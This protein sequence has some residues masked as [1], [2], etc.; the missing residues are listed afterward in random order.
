MQSVKTFLATLSILLLLVPGAVPISGLGFTPAAMAQ[1]APLADEDA[2]AKASASLDTQ[3]KQ[4]DSVSAYLGASDIN[5]RDILT[6][7]SKVDDVL[8]ALVVMKAQLNPRLDAM[9]ARLADLGAAP[10]DDQ[11][12]EALEVT[13]QRSK[14]SA[15][16]TRTV[17]VLARI[18]DMTKVA[19]DLSAKISTIR[20]E[21]FTRELLAHADVSIDSMTYAVSTV[22]PEVSRFADTMGNWLGFV[23]RLKAMSLASA[24]VLS[25][26]MMLGLRVVLHRIFGPIVARGRE[27]QDPSYMSRFSLAFWVTIIPSLGF[28]FFLGTSFLF[29]DMFNVLRPDI[30]QIIGSLFVFVGFLFFAIR[31]SLVVFNPA[32][33]KWRLLHVSDRGSRQLMAA[34]VTM[35][36][37]NGFDYVLSTISEVEG[38]PV[39]ITVLKGLL[40][41]IIVGLVLLWVSFIKPLL[42]TDELSLETGRPWPPLTVGLLRLLSAVIIFSALLGYVGFARFIVTQIVLTGGVVCTMYIGIRSGKAVSERDRFADTVVGRFFE[43]RFA[44]GPVALDQMGIAA[45][46]LIYIVAVL[47]GVPLIMM[48]WGFQPPDIRLWLFDLFTEIKIGSIS[49]SVVGII[50]GG[51]LFVVGMLLTRWF[52]KWLD[53]NVMARS[54]MD[55]GVRNSVKT[56]VGYFGAIVAAVMGL[57]AAGIN[58]SSLALVAG[59]LSVGIGFGLQNIISNFVSGLILLFERPFKVGDWVATG[60]SEGFVR[61]ISV[62]ATE[63]E[64]FQRQSIIVPNSQLI[65]AS[66]GNWTHRNKLGRVEVKIVAKAVNDPRHL[67]T[68]LK[69]VATSQASILRTPEPVVVFKDFTADELEFE[70]RVFVADVLTGLS[71]R[72]ELRLGIFEKFRA[73]GVFMADPPA[74]EGEGESA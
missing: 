45:G 12:A 27:E 37:V 50:G 16:K 7:K 40:A 3:Q 14:L 63:I 57:S 65:N 9:T 51:L 44:F 67:M 54:Q 42:P 8:A 71:V 15:L 62:R 69:E 53:G 55:P 17:S 61:R 34:F 52:E 33:P 59:A 68:L 2:I 38:W 35:A 74:Q 64:T 70:V 24:L 19:N 73:E 36:S 56:S 26:I 31:L 48:S 1:D 18:D 49:I 20:R 21:L 58:L 39:D 5:D 29:L 43:R 30:R 25:L 32:A 6:R 4:L 47:I 60:T 10:K 23:F 11:P 46:L 41:A 66:V 22:G 72:N 28:A 13:T